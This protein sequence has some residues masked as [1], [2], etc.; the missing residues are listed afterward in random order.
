MVVLTDFAEFDRLARSMMEANPTA[1]RFSVKT[2][3]GEQQVIVKVADDSKSV[4]FTP[5]DG[6]SVKR[7]EKL[8]RWFVEKMVGDKIVE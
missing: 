2:R 3:Q 8:S 6:N 1:C 5:T 7:I 4:K